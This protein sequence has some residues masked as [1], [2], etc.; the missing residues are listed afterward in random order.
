[1][2]ATNNSSSSSTDTTS[3]SFGLLMWHPIIAE[4]LDFPDIL[5][6]RS[7]CREWKEGLDQGG[8]TKTLCLR[9]LQRILP[10]RNCYVTTVQVTDE[11]TTTNCRDDSSSSS[12]S[13]GPSS[14]TTTT[15]DWRYVSSLSQHKEILSRILDTA[16]SINKNGTS[17]DASREPSSNSFQTLLRILRVVKHL[18]AQMAICYSQDYGRHCLGMEW[19]PDFSNDDDTTTT[20]IHHHDHP[21]HNIII[22]SFTYW[23]NL[24]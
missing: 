4:Y 20:T 9:H 1:M 11:D 8:I 14:V 3:S 7:I 17:D 16:G 18:P 23:Y 21:N 5:K 22:N 10:E 19:V 2:A 6:A 24:I 12:S 13:S 15:T